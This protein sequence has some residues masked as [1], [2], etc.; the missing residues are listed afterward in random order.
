M[1]Y[2][3]F[4]DAAGPSRS[5]D[6]LSAL[7][8]PALSGKRFLD[9][10]CNEGFFCGFAQF[11]GASR[12]VGID[13]N[14]E[15]LQRAA[16]RFPEVTFLAQGWDQLPAESFDVIT[17]LSALHYAED[18]EALI[19]RLMDHLTAN[20]LLVLEIGLSSESQN[21]W[22]E[23]KRSIDTRYFPTRSK[24]AEIL[25][26][27]AWKLIGNSVA[28]PGDPVKRVVVH[29]RKLK[30]YAYLMMESPASGKSTL[31]RQLFK[32][33]KVPVLGGDSLYAKIARGDLK[34]SEALLSCVQPNFKTYAIDKAVERV[35]AKGLH[36]EFLDLLIAKFPDQDLAIDTYVPKTYWPEVMQWM[37]DKGYFPVLMSWEGS[38]EL[39]GTDT[40]A[41]QVNRYQQFLS[42]KASDQPVYTVKRLRKRHHSAGMRWHLDFPVNG[43]FFLPKDAKRLEG[44]VCFDRIKQPLVIMEIRSGDQQI[45]FSLNRKRDDVWHA[46]L[47]QFKQ[48]QSL[49]SNI[50][51]G[52]SQAVDPAWFEDMIL[53]IRVDGEQYDLAQISVKTSV[54]KRWFGI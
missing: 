31:G 45:N 52:F 25:K 30:P 14:A 15:T 39:I 37:R 49:P 9:V 28:Q 17:L 1:Q 19:H 24:L 26:P 44:W 18:Q 36:G 16:L 51:V 50:A 29:I 47:P 6:K 41:K 23:V 40:Y 5:L 8:I 33:A 32:Q 53:S 13:R 4:P 46:L 43:Q 42:A 34:V 27:Y 2:Q 12:V 35:F 38:R 10:G 48:L 22:I 11:S 21:E 7:R 20:G 54:R 3:S